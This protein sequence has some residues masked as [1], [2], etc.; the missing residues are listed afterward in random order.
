RARQ[1]FGERD[2][3]RALEAGNL[4]ADEVAALLGRVAG[5]RPHPPDRPDGLAPFGVGNT[6]HA[7]AAD[8]VHLDDHRLDL[9]WIDVLAA[10]LDQLPLKLAAGHI[11]ATRS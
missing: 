9:G 11:E 8:A 10:R 5:G 1:G 3:A 6:E 7:G 2:P 4:R